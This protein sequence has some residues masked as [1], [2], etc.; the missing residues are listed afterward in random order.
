MAKPKD[1][2]SKLFAEYYCANITDAKFKALHD[3]N[4]RVAL[5]SLDLDIP[6]QSTLSDIIYWT[7]H[8]LRGEIEYM[9][10]QIKE[11]ESTVNR[12]TL[13]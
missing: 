11:L 9:R 3:P 12:L 5:L 6:E 4:L 13:R 10:G 7:I 8:D 2:L 1:K